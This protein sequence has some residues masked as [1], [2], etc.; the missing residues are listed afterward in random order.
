[1]RYLISIIVISLISSY[2][3]AGKTSGWGTIESL[4]VRGDSKVVRVI[5]SK[6]QE[7]PDG[8][9]GAADW[10][11]NELTSEN[12]VFMSQLIAAFYSQKEV[13]FWI[14]GCTSGLHYNKTWPNMYDI[15]VK[16]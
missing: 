16:K 1:M 9:T 12:N 7:N 6:T 4:L 14:A 11:I 2:S 13:R 5:F 3:Y 10:Y 8:C 15:E